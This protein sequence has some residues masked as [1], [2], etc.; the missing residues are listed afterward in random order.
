[1]AAIHNFLNSILSLTEE[2]LCHK[3]F[4]SGN[5]FFVR[6]IPT[7]TICCNTSRRHGQKTALSWVDVYNIT[8]VKMSLIILHIFLQ[9]QQQAIIFTQH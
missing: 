5:F 4:S 3:Y 1:M 2:N 6:Q 7:F 9:Q 8:T